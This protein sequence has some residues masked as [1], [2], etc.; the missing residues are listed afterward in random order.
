MHVQLSRG[1]SGL[2]KSLAQLAQELRDLPEAGRAEVLRLVGAEPVRAHW[3]RD[4]NAL[5]RKHCIRWHRGKTATA[6]A[7]AVVYDYD[8]YSETRWRFD[9]RKASPPDDIR[10]TR[11]ETMFEIK[12]LGGLFPSAQHIR[13]NILGT[14]WDSDYQANL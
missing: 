3:L 5:I 12:R 6:A 7:E 14:N 10:A 2:T 8:R 11:W 9:Q 13:R 1:E 4:R